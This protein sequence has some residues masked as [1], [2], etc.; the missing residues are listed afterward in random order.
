M[1]NKVFSDYAAYYDLLYADKDYGSEVDYIHQ[2]ISQ[3]SNKQPRTLLDI[4]CGTGKHAEL[5]SQKGLTVHG[6]DQSQDMISI[7]NEKTNESLSFGCGDFAN[8]VVDKQFDIVTS[9][10]HVLNYITDTNELSKSIANVKKH[11][12]ANGLFIFDFWYGPAVLT[13]RPHQRYR[14]FE[15][16]VLAV[17]RFVSPEMHANKNTVDVNYSMIIEPAKEDAVYRVQE[18]HTMRYFFLP[19]IEELLLRNDFVIRH[20][21]KWMESDTELSYDTWYGIIVAELQN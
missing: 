11:L 14:L 8:F 19:E 18:K 4:G 5:L 3:Y 21:S 15:N 20:C 12:Q 16:N 7:A 9:L 10:F 6:V 13:D 17:H 1:S 2:L